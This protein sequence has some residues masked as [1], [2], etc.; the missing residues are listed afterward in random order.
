MHDRIMS[1]VVGMKMVRINSKTVIGT[2]QVLQ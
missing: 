2:M 1:N